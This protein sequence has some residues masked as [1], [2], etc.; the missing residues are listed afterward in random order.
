MTSEDFTYDN[1]THPVRVYSSLSEAVKA[2][3]EPIPSSELRVQDSETPK[4]LGTAS[5]YYFRIQS[6]VLLCIHGEWH[7][8]TR[9]DPPPRRIA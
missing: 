2:A 9:D 4:Y 8:I 6:Q 1:T 3:A 5:G 7:E